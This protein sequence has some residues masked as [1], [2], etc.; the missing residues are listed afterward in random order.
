[1]N[2]FNKSDRE[3]ISLSDFL[4]KFSLISNYNISKIQTRSLTLVFPREGNENNNIK[5]NSFYVTLHDLDMF[6]PI[7]VCRWI[8]ACILGRFV[9]SLKND[10]SSFKYKLYKYFIDIYPE[11]KKL[12]MFNDA[13]CPDY[14]QNF[15]TYTFYKDVYNSDYIKNPTNSEF[16]NNKIIQENVINNIQLYNSNLNFD[17]EELVDVLYT[18]NKSDTK[19]NGFLCSTNQTHSFK[20]KLDFD[21]NEFKEDI[22]SYIN[23][24]ENFIKKFVESNNTINVH[25]YCSNHLVPTEPRIVFNLYWEDFIQNVLEQTLVHNKNSDRVPSTFEELYQ[26]YESDVYFN[27]IGKRVHENSLLVDQPELTI[28][29]LEFTPKDENKY[30][31]LKIS[32]NVKFQD[33]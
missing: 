22:L 31:P 28:I 25:Y 11:F 13:M 5:S 9:D 24:S 4:S 16:D 15:L 30:E 3:V 8:K 17:L 29:Q 10:T 2:S 14:C 18:F 32:I 6:E 1:M 21:Y 33:E 20:C 23:V 27:L 26:N 7:D 12:N 19:C